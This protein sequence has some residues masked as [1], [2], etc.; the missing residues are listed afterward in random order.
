MTSATNTFIDGAAILGTLEA[1]GARDVEHTSTWALQCSVEV[2]TLLLVVPSVCL[3]PIPELHQ[4]PSGP[5]GK[6]L[7]LLAEL[8]G[9]QRATPA[10]E[11]RAL[12]T[13]QQWGAR[14]ADRLAMV[15]RDLRGDDSYQEWLSWLSRHQWE[16]H[17]RRHG[18]LYEN[19]FIRPL[20]TALNVPVADL[21][22]IRSDCG[23]DL[24]RSQE[25][26]RIWDER[27]RIVRDAFTL[28]T[29]LRGRHY[30]TLATKLSTHVIHH[31]IRRS[32][33]SPIPRVRDV[34]VALPNT[35]WFLSIIVVASA[36][37]TRKRDRAAQWVS[38]IQAA[39]TQ[40]AQGL[41]DVRAKSTD[42]VALEVA[43][44]S[45]QGLGLQTHSAW[46]DR[47]L[48]ASVSAGLGG[49]ASLV[50][51]SYEAAG[52]GF[53]SDLV[54]ETTSAVDRVTRRLSSRE[55]RLEKI[56]RLGAG[57]LTPEWK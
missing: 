37:N 46:V 21:R 39:R 22:A 1:L 31:P 23:V 54:L 12:R 40:I 41:V 15:L 7:T 50:V 27:D 52:I 56:A 17:V 36:F 47:V 34:R 55:R 5:Y 26:R 28:S 29:L 13:T 2:T 35:A 30:E 32:I 25:P 9:Q 14:N 53:A 38:A 33:L 20:S 48:N 43:A 18:G 16:D 11:S 4:P 51:S 6:V 44:R 24:K 10:L 49:I 19:A 3:S 45:A 42:D 57:R 8:V